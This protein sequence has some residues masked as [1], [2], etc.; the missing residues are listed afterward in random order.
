MNHILI[1]K[2]KQFHTIIESML[3]A[4]RQNEWQIFFA[5]QTQYL[6]LSEY[7][8]TYDI[9]EILTE[10]RSQLRITIME[11]IND[12]LNS[13][14]QL[15]LLLKAQHTQLGKL[16]GETVDQQVKIN[17]YHQIATLT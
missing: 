5:L 13:Q 2:Y 10:D 1:E 12:I 14:Q 6:T 17:H 3:T 11:S 8:S 4:V 15:S 7:L 9:T 16:I